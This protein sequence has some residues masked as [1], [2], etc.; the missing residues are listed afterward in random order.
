M[1]VSDTSGGSTTL[2]GGAVKG[3]GERPGLRG[4]Y[5]FCPRKVFYNDCICTM[6]LWNHGYFG[7][8]RKDFLSSTN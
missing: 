5:Y 2:E 8:I 7:I 6:G 3:E 4:F 1:S